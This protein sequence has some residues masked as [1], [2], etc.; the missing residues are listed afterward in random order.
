MKK[1]SNIGWWVAGAAALFLLKKKAAAAV[2]GIGATKNDTLHEIRKSLLKDRIF[3]EV[4]RDDRGE[5]NVWDVMWISDYGNIA[6]RHYGQSANPNT[7]RDLKWVITNIFDTTPDKFV[8]KYWETFWENHV[9]Y[10]INPYTGEVIV[11]QDYR[12]LY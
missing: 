5:W 11:L 8:K 1:K 7:L 3:S 6:W 9:R 4:R 12:D 10:G 2:E